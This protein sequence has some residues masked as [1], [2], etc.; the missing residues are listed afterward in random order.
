M[1]P[2]VPLRSGHLPP[3]HLMQKGLFSLSPDAVGS[4][5]PCRVS[6]AAGWGRGDRTNPGRSLS[7]PGGTEIT[8]CILLQKRFHVPLK[9]S[10]LDR[11]WSN[12]IV[13]LLLCWELSLP[14]AGEAQ[15]I[16]GVPSDPNHPGF[17]DIPFPHG[18]LRVLQ[19]VH[20]AHHSAHCAV[21]NSSCCSGAAGKL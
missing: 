19:E 15:T 11:T 2:P 12:G 20:G 18:Q 10:R 6:P 9:C 5:E 1:P 4:L 3:L 13:S 7:G 8:L 17:C 14:M 16:P 21:E